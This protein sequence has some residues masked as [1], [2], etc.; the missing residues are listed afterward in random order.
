MGSATGGSRGSMD[1]PRIKWV[2][3]NRFGPPN[4]LKNITILFEN[5]RNNN[6]FKNSRQAIMV[7]ISKHFSKFRK[8]VSHTRNHFIFPLHT[9]F[10]YFDMYFLINII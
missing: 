2:S 4:F 5:K 3:S 9:I 1:P 10:E 6:S 8:I 7:S